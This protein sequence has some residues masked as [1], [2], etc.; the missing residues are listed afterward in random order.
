D[1][2]RLYDPSKDS[3][4]GGNGAQ[5]WSDASTWGG[6]GDRLPVVQLYAL[7]RGIRWNGQWLYGLQTVTE[8]RLPAS[9]W[10]AQIGKCRTLIEGA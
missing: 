10:I 9:H 6:D 3:S 8:R 7:M 5:R 1:G 4:V 2:M